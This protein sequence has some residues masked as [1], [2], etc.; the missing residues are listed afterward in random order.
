MR[1]SAVSQARYK[2]IHRAP[3][4]AT[5]STC[6]S[7]NWIQTYFSTI[8]SQHPLLPL[9][10]QYNAQHRNISQK[11]QL[12]LILEGITRASLQETDI[13]ATYMSNTQ[14][15][16]VMLLAAE[17][18]QLLQH[19]KIPTADRHLL[20]LLQMIEALATCFNS[21]RYSS[22]SL[23]IGKPGAG[24]HHPGYGEGQIEVQ[25]VILRH[26]RGD[27]VS[28]SDW[29]KFQKELDTDLKLDA[30]GLQ[31][32]ISDSE[33][34]S[35]E[36]DQN[37]RLQCC[38]Q[39]GG[40]GIFKGRR[41]GGNRGGHNR[42]NRAVDTY[43]NVNNHSLFSVTPLPPVQANPETSSYTVVP[44]LS[45]RQIGGPT[46]QLVR[47]PDF[48]KSN[49]TPTPKQQS[50]Q[51][52]PPEGTPGQPQPIN[53]QQQITIHLNP[54][55]SETTSSN[56]ISIPT[57]SEHQI[58]QEQDHLL[59][60]PVAVSPYSINPS[61]I[62]LPPVVDSQPNDMIQPV[63]NMFAPQLS[64]PPNSRSSMTTQPIG[65][66]LRAEQE[67][68]KLLNQVLEARNKGFDNI[69]SINPFGNFQSK[70][71]PNQF[72]SNFDRISSQDQ[73]G[74]TQSKLKV[75]GQR[76]GKTGAADGT[77]NPSAQSSHINQITGG[78]DFNFGSG[79]DIDMEQMMERDLTQTKPTTND[80]LIVSTAPLQLGT[81]SLHAGGDSA[82]FIAVQRANIEHQNNGNEMNIPQHDHLVAQRAE[83]LK[84]LPL[85]GQELGQSQKEPEQDQGQLNI[86]NVPD[87]LQNEGPPGHT[88]ET[89]RSK[90]N[91]GSIKPRT[92]SSRKKNGR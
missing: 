68:Q 24:R 51:P 36:K 19:S 37:F 10:Y 3:I 2:C 40:S 21:K 92:K 42:D 48:W 91:K 33:E 89:R 29:R 58:Q 30:V 44:D 76:R 26:A 86:N 32:P 59:H 80:G 77:I 17:A 69:S 67:A 22:L 85:I 8:D 14:V 12:V 54:Q 39:R 31:S 23:Y 13:Y 66:D 38:G 52:T 25:E 57:P 49:K 56:I 73:Q 82:N 18:P 35:N 64:D 83:I 4:R 9:I 79:M 46:P 45:Q 55:S 5:Q 63:N 74:S 78:S 84:F 50:K 70:Y 60:P 90:T 6:P 75:P 7:R 27:K 61:N 41:Y 11:R 62:Q 47:T 16:E 71:N 53:Q 34:Q 72:I 20:L 28:I 81:A 15:H 43:H 1:V 87:N 88:Q 65:M